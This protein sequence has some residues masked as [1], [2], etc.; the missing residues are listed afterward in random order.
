M[1]FFAVGG[2][3]FA[4]AA[5]AA[6]GAVP[7]GLEKSV[8]AGLDCAS[9]HS[10]PETGGMAK[11]DCS[12]CHD[13]PAKALG[14]TRHGQALAR[15][16]GAGAGACLAC[17]GSGHQIKK[18]AAEG[19]PT[20]RANQPA[21]CGACHGNGGKGAHMPEGHA[22]LESYRLS[23]HGQALAAGNAKAAAC[24][25]CHGGHDIRSPGKAGSKVGRANLAATCGACHAKE[26]EGY[27]GGVH[28]R[29]LAR[30]VRE[31]PSCTDCHGE[32]TIRSPK[33][34]GSSVWRGSV[35]KTCSG[36]HGSERI[37]AK[38]G[39]P[40]DR[41]KT[42]MDSYHGLAAGGGNLSVANCASCHG[43]HDILPSDDP[44]STVHGGNLAGTCGQCHPGA[45][46]KLSGGKVHASLAG[47]GEGSRIAAILKKIYLIL[48]PLVILGL[49]FHNFADLL[50]K[51]LASAPLPPLKDETGDILLTRGE[52][53]QHGAL[54][55][56]FVLLAISGFALK[57][58]GSWLAA[59]FSLL[60]GEGGR[61]YAH[62]AAAAAFVALAVVHLGYLAFSAPG[63]RR[64][65]AIF[66]ARRDLPDA[67]ALLLF[68]LGL[69]GDRPK[70]PRWC[71]I[72]KSEYW[73]LMWGSAVM[74]ATG[75][76]LIFHNFVMAKFPLWVIEASRVVHF[77]EAVLA[78]LSIIVWHGYWVSFDPEVYPMSWAWL[79]GRHRLGGAHR[80]GE[81]GHD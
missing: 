4:F 47:F 29:A 58:S 35:T 64:L 7:P 70:L 38:F 68:N 2:V 27:R 45:A 69:S 49:L 28:G 77:M 81:P 71:Y 36:C 48:I 32:H 16:K 8:H 56:S 22:A 78:C 66:P 61:L 21:P 15:S 34:S 41:L 72:E 65:R 59:A 43:W 11:A 3:L 80:K 60:G 63:R 9:C 67:A 6:F 12:T 76:V 39:V 26:A 13:G 14:A 23:V 44:R 42:F 52:R 10:G 31:S 17:H 74:I 19:S 18:A 53:L 51:A 24:S 73:A 40:T 25:D 46:M 33:E 79:T 55:A 50:R 5:S 20:G 75:A 57:Y 30:G 62:R 54:V 1:N 37:A